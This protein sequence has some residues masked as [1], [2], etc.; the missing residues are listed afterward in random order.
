MAAA[1]HLLKQNRLEL[2]AW[3]RSR[4]SEWLEVERDASS[5]LSASPF[6]VAARL[7][8]L[9]D[10]DLHLGLMQLLGS[11]C[12]VVL[13]LPT[14]EAVRIARAQA[15]RDEWEGIVYIVS[16]AEWIEIL[17]GLPDTAVMAV[18]A[19]PWLLSADAL[20]AASRLAESAAPAAGNL[21]D[22]SA[23]F[24]GLASDLRGRAAPCPQFEQCLSSLERILRQ[25]T[26][27]WPA[28]AEAN[29]SGRERSLE[30]ASWAAG[31][32]APHGRIDFGAMRSGDELIVEAIND[33]T[34]STVLIRRHGEL[35]STTPNLKFRAP[36]RLLTTSPQPVRIQLT[37][38]ELRTQRAELLLHV[39]ASRLQPWMI[40]AFLNR[41]GGGNP[42]IRAFAEGVGCRIA[43]AEDEP[44]M[45]Q[46][47]PVVWGVLRDS[48]RILAQ[49]KAQK[50]YF[51]YIDHAYFNRGH[52]KAYR[53][54]RNAYEAGAVR[55][56]PDDRLAA[57]D[58]TVEPWRKGGREV[59]VCPPTEYFMNAH[60][61]PNWL[62]ETLAK[63]RSLT[64]R[65][66]VIRSKPQP[67]ETAV[68]LPDVLKT[69]HALVTHSS[70]VAIVAAC[71]GTP[72]FV[73]PTSAAA[74]IGRTDL[75]D[76]EDPAYPDRAPWLAHL[77]YNQFSLNEIGDGK[78]W[79]MLLELEERDLA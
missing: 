77:A 6:I 79:R 67:G 62:E 33:E 71:L 26:G 4:W 38:G 18:F 57:L 23:V 20:A 25:N 27:N 70:N 29:H 49:A 63:L 36:A 1:R 16:D 32:D 17:D 45:L 12:R 41:G 75:S 74:P 22:G 35:L 15:R 56:C 37:D 48:D 8:C 76:L 30:A 9:A 19:V 61:C 65:P 53:I 58:V 78:A 54:T 55:K 14:D 11:N 28:V 5:P 42:V 10:L 13:I 69:A 44:A 7:S 3:S 40:A 47:I 2:L 51:F 64:D 59:I 68:P 34:D 50:L 21:F 24:L 43:Y 72:I 39:A 60:G 31:V 52:G 46:D 73:S 66:I